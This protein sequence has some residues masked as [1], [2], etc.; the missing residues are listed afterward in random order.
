MKLLIAT[1]NLGKIRE[2]R[3]IFHDLHVKIVSLEEEGITMEPK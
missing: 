2:Y 1:N 3:E